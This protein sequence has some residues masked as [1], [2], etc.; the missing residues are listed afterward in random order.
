MSIKIWITLLVFINILF[1]TS[2]WNWQTH[3]V[4]VES[5]YYTTNTSIELNLTL[6]KIGSI[7]PDKVFKDNARHSYPAALDEAKKWLSRAK[8]A[9]VSGNSN[10]ASFT[11]GVASHYTSDMFA[12]PH[13]VKEESSKDHSY[14]EDQ[15]EYSYEFVPCMEDSTLINLDKELE[16]AIR[17][18]QEEWENWISSKDEKIP[19]NS[20]ADAM[21]FF[22]K[23]YKDTFNATCN[24]LPDAKSIS[25]IRFLSPL[26]ILSLAIILIAII[27]LSISLLKELRKN[28]S[29]SF[30]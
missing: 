2:A 18:K 30:K 11:F 28:N 17:T 21:Q 13:N 6:L 1:L 5:L 26:K 7:T 19:Q 15:A 14:Y 24:D 12:A 23:V 9:Y 8:E 25:R 4:F 20:V 27:F 22:Y 29:Y 16:D 3:E 10:E